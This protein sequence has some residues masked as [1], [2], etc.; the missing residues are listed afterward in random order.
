[1]RPKKTDSINWTACVLR[2]PPSLGSR[3]ELFGGEE[4]VAEGEEDA[5]DPD[6][7]DFAVAVGAEFEGR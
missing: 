1:M 2:G 5:E 6:G 7:A 3:L 4:G